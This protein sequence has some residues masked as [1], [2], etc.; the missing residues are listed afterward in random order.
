MGSVTAC[1]RPIVET[2]PAGQ[3]ETRCSDRARSAVAELADRLGQPAAEFTASG[4]AAIEVALEVLRI[5]SG[6]EVIVPDLGCYSVAAAVIRRGAVPVFVGVGE[7]LTLGPQDAAVALSRATRAIIA[8]HQYG[9]PCDVRALVDHVPPEVTIIEDVAQTWGSSTHGFASGSV[10]ALTVTSFGPQKPV[11]LGGGGALFGPAAITGAV[12]RGDGRESELP[13]PPSPARFPLPLLEG[14][15]GAIDRADASLA[16]RR[17]AV[18][19]F[20]DSG[21]SAYFRLPPLPTGGAASWTAVP[22]YPAGR[23]TGAQLRAVRD[24]LGA[25]ELMPRVP[26]SGMRVFSDFEKRIVPG[27]RRRSDPLLV[28]IPDSGPLR[29]TGRGS[30]AQPR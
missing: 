10:G 30:S 22:L 12:S 5:G 21:L 6:D 7:S 20:L 19:A 27:S 17:L 25:I 24:A 16:A 23:A 4:T 11:C 9:L 13:R 3:C 28:R 14:L 15:P 8:V 18:A 26:P 1:N 29:T 2:G